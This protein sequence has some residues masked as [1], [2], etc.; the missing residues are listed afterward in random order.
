[1]APTLGPPTKRFKSWAKAHMEKFTKFKG[2][3]LANQF[4]AQKIN[5]VFLT[6]LFNW[7]TNNQAF[8][9]HSF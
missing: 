4:S 3:F 2:E 6:I 8:Q 9:M 5:K 7:K 1:V